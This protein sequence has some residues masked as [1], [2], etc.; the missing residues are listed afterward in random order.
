MFCGFQLI[1]N[2][3][4]EIVLF[5]LSIRGGSI[6]GFKLVFNIDSEAAPV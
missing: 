6:T 4:C 3:Q 1:V 2:N 5:S